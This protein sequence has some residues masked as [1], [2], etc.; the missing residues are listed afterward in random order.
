MKTQSPGRGRR[1]A[2]E[3]FTSRQGLWMLAL[4]ILIPITLGLLYVLGYL[5]LDA[6]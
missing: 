4:L 3:K 1:K 2:V 5:H 6:D